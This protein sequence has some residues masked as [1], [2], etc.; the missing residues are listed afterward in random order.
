VAVLVA[1]E[2]F[3]V[4]LITLGEMV[5]LVVV[6]VVAALQVLLEQVPEVLAILLL[7]LLHREMPVAQAVTYQVPIKQA[8]AVV[9]RDKQEPQ[10]VIILEVTEETA[11]LL[12]SL[13]LL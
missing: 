13:D 7:H 8:A 6:V 3:Q 5:A 10:Q 12:P 9:V 11:L 2:G 1:E 4:I